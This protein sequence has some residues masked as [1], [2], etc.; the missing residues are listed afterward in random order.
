MK[1]G[2]VWGLVEIELNFEAESIE[3]S[4]KE[5]PRQDLLMLQSD[6]QQKYLVKDHGAIRDDSVKLELKTLQQTLHSW[7]NSI[8]SPLAILF[9]EAGVYA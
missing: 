8:M 5:L 4:Q 2:D 3:A 6:W 1:I 7:Y 9:Q